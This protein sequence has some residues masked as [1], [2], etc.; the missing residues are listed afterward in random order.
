VPLRI[1]VI[2]D[3]PN[4]R[5]LLADLLRATG[6]DVVETTNGREALQRMEADGD[7]D[8]V[9]TDLGMPDLSGWEVAR[10]VAGRPDPPP[11]ILVTGWGIQLEDGIL[12]ESGVAAVIAKP[13][14][15]EEVLGAVERVM[16][17]AA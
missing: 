12:A 10:V 8:L 16:R 17:R 9:M 15:I 4:V 1:M 3:E 14:T 13:F 2:D 5:T 7:W 6:H 11:V